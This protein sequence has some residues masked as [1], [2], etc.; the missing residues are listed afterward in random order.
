MFGQ[1]SPD[2]LSRF[3]AYTETRVTSPLALALL[4][5]DDSPAWLADFW[6]PSSGSESAGNCESLCFING[7]W[8]LTS[9]Y[10]ITRNETITQSQYRLYD[11]TEPYV[12]ELVH[13]KMALKKPQPL[14]PATLG[15]QH[16]ISSAQLVEE[17]SEE[18]Y[19]NMPHRLIDIIRTRAHT[20]FCNVG[21]D[22]LLPGVLLKRPHSS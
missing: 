12:A 16:Y 19:V 13:P 8:P 1:T 7:Q 18:T 15:L 20:E 5:S 22:Q 11:M 17:N 3:S 4:S 9:R 2:I 10:L 21:P 14:P 6:L